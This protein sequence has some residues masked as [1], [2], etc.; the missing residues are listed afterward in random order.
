M[1]ITAYV[2]CAAVDIF[3]QSNSIDCLALL[4]LVVPGFSI[5]SYEDKI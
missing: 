5:I 3:T 2:T 4:L 1:K